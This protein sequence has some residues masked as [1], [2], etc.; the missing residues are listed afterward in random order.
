MR[1]ELPN[2]RIELITTFSRRSGQIQMSVCG[3][4]RHSASQTASITAGT[5]ATY[6]TSNARAKSYPYRILAFYSQSGL[7]MGAI[8]N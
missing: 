5:V 1:Q 2:I 4:G 6:L 8:S 7:M 3:V